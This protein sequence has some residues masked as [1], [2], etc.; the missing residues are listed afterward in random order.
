MDKAPKSWRDRIGL[1]IALLGF[2]CFAISLLFL[3]PKSDPNR[4]AYIPMPAGGL[5]TVIGL[6]VVEG[7][8]GAKAKCAV[9]ADGETPPSDGAAP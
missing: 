3:G 4:P 8:K 5:V 2:A 6:A 1:G 7:G 9:G